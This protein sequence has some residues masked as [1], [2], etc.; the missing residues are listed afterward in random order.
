[1]R[2]IGLIIL[3][4]SLLCGVALYVTTS[5]V[6]PYSPISIHPSFTY[7]PDQ[8]VVKEYA[9][10]VTAFKDKFEE[11]LTT[12][13]SEDLTAYRMQYVLKMYEQSWLLN[14]EGRN[15]TS[16]ELDE[17][18]QYVKDARKVIIELAFQEDYSRNDRSNLRVLLEHN[19]TLEEEIQEIQQSVF[20]SQQTLDRQMG[21]LHMSFIQNFNFFTTFYERYINEDA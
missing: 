3:A 15:M 14:T 13:A 7:E 19:L 16:E 17:I 10:D 9:E 21:N 18:L 2:R 8:V 20:H 12:S 6:Y 4:G 11:P 5:W 1:M